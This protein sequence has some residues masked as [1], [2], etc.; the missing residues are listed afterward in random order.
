MTYEMR[1]NPDLTYELVI[2]ER[3]QTRCEHFADLEALL[4]RADQ[5]TRAARTADCRETELRFASWL[6]RGERQL[7]MN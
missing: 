3:G 7:V 5:L 4:A 6:R 1:R 2:D